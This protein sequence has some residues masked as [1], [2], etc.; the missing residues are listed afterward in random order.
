MSDENPTPSGTEIAPGLFIPES[1]L[2]FSFARSGGP[3]GQNVNKV[4][5]KARLAILLADLQRILARGTYERLLVQAASRINDAGDLVITSDES[6]SQLAN[7]AICLERL[8]NI[9]LEAKRVPRVRRATKPSKSAKQ[10]RL[11]AKKHRGEIKRGRGGVG[12]EG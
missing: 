9:L 1:A 4:S 11:G 5:S 2:H 8:R 12:D 10:R 3:G 6:R 7:R